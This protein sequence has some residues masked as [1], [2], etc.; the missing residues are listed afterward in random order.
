MSVEQNTEIETKK[1]NKFIPIIV[2][3]VVIAL[4]FFIGKKVMYAMHHEDTENSQIETNIS[5]I[6]SRIQGYVTDILVND[7]HFVKKGDLLVKIDDR[8]L[9]LKLQQ[10][11]INLQNA[12]ANL[13]VVRTNVRTA[14]ANTNVGNTNV[15]SYKSNIEIAKIR[16][17]KANQDFTRYKNLFDQNSIT[18]QQYDMA[19]ADKETADQQVFAAQ[20]QLN[21]IEKQSNVSSAQEFSTEKQIKLAELA[22]DQRQADIDNAKLSLSYCNITAPF[23]GYIAKKAIQP[24][25]LINV[26]Q[27]LMNLVDN[28]NVWITANFKETQL[29]KMQVGQQVKIDVDAYPKEHFTGTIES[30]SPATGAKFSLIPPDNASG[31]FV[32]VVQRVPVRISIKNDDASHPLRA[33]M[34]V[35]VDVSLS[36]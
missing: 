16:A 33:G 3:I 34:N 21:V 5:P 15:E 14:G 36:K 17:Q 11:E 32:K 35:N 25:Q 1:K 31:N 4:A 9:Q 8:D 20:K 10:A 24:G 13:E 29:E 2:G 27:S 26:G 30:F 18:K 12:R 23:D 28:K 6:A 22:I 7:N 19:K